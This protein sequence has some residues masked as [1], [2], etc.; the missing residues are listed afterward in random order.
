MFLS[1]WSRSWKRQWLSFHANR[2]PRRT[3]RPRCEQLEARCQPA[4]FS[5]STGAPD[6]RM[7]SAS[8]PANGAAFE[9][10][11]ADDFV[12]PTETSI[13]SATFTGLIPT[14][15]T[16]NQ[17]VV[18]I[19]RV[20]PKDSN[21]GR[22]SGAP[23]FSTP[24]VPTRVNSPSDIAFN[25]RDSSDMNQLTFTTAPLNPT[26]MAANS[27]QPGGIHAF[28]AQTT[29]GNGAVTGVETQFN[30]TFVTPFDLPADH[31]FFVPQVL[32]ST[33]DF[34]WLSAPKPIV[35]PGT[36]FSPDLQAWTRDDVA[37]NNIAPDWLRIGTDI[38]G[39][40]T[41]PTF[42]A[43]F[44]LSGQTFT[45]QITSLSQT[46]A[47]EGSAGFNLTVNGSDFT[48]G[49]TVVWNGLPLTTTFVSA[50]QLQAAVP[51]SL[52][53]DEG[54]ANVSVFDAQRGISNAQTF[55]VLETVPAVSATATVSRASRRVTVNGMFSD[56]ALEG[57]KV[58]INWGDGFT[59]VLDLGVSRT[60]SFFRS[61]KFKGFFPRR[62]TI[63][64]NVLDDE[65]TTSATLTLFVRA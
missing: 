13:T 44:S 38:V 21:V 8:R 9:I 42:N 65:G 25:T 1:V 20:F 45:P 47:A 11:S 16:V 57:H 43:S 2:R 41:P 40:P 23:T 63:K 62:R 54:S 53:A 39:G 5:F 29:G 10:E 6:G 28:P 24:E 27:V 59:D 46:A 48:G 58:R 36:P 37:P 50:T 31:F 32:L 18:A 12:L 26:F 14:G 15:A 34:L 49:S 4:A 64:I 56:T 7:A 3:Q 35:S 30:V 52:L 19:Y 61:H 17:V 60:G 51:S 22:T 33:G 55:S